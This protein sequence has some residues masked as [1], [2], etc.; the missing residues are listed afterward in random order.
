MIFQD[1]GL[2]YSRLARQSE[3]GKGSLK[4]KQQYKN[5][6]KM[7]FRDNGLDYSRLARQ[8]EPG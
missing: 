7:I 6:I 8:S 4:L 2:D 3:P 1:N 5:S